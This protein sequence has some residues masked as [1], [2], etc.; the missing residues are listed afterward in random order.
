ML[1]TVGGAARGAVPAERERLRP[2]L[3]PALARHPFGTDELGR[4]L[5]TRVLYGGRTS[6][7]VAFLATALA[8]LAGVAWGFVAAFR[9]GGL[10]ELLMRIA[11]C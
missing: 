6:L 8:M 2:S 5:L 3:C 1:G 9:E 7:L 4:D 11:D 10:D